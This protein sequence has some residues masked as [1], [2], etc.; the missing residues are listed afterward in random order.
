MGK[1]PV[2]SDPDDFA[3]DLNVYFEHV[4]SAHTKARDGRWLAE[5]TGGV[6]SKGYWSGLLKG[7]RAMNTND[8][9]VIAR[10]FN[11]SAFD[12]VRYA[13][14]FAHGKPVPVL[15]VG[16][17]PEDYEISKDP[18]EFERQAAETPRTPGD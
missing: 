10:I 11:V 14:D 8:I 3:T 16:A 7:T 12:F 1:K 17:H 6:R 2:G 4:V 9:D 5:V 18:G 15:N 13:R